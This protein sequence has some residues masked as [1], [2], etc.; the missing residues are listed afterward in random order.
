MLF[1]NLNI[2]CI[3]L[4]KDCFLKELCKR[5]S[6]DLLENQLTGVIKTQTLSIRFKQLAM[7]K[8][9]LQTMNSIFSLACS[10]PALSHYLYFSKML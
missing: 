9:S 7:T 3:E 2:L 10:L 4:P 5:F 8:K 6:K 1:H